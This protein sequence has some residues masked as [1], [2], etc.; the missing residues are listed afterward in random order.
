MIVSPPQLQRV[1][2]GLR[3]TLGLVVFG[4]S[5]ATAI[6]AS[7]ITDGSH[8][9]P[10]LLVLAGIESVAAL[11]FLLPRTTAPAAATLVVIFAVAIA[12]H[13]TTGNGFPAHLL[14]YIAAATVV[15][16]HD[17]TAHSRAAPLDPSPGAS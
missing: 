2:T 6:S 14:V 16:V 7:G 8:H 15:A 9:N 4:Q 5:L 11:L 3:L 1:F 10:A 12:L 13:L 17:R